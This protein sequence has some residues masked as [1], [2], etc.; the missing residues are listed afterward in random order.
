MIVTLLAWSFVAY[1]KSFTAAFI[2]NSCV[3]LSWQM[4]MVIVKMNKLQGGKNLRMLTITDIGKELPAV[5]V[6]Y[7][8]LFKKEWDV[9]MVLFLMI[10]SVGIAFAFWMTYIAWMLS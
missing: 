3:R 10:A 4:L 1:L 2:T 5:I 7:F 8:A 6:A 9:L